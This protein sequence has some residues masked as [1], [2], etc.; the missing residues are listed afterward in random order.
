MKKRG[1]GVYIF[2]IGGVIL[3]LVGGFLI[4]SSPGTLI[5]KS[6]NILWIALNLIFD[7]L[8]LAG[9]AASIGVLLLK[10][11]ARRLFMAASLIMLVTVLYS[12]AIVLSR[13]ELNIK[14][15]ILGA[16][17]GIIPFS[18]PIIYFRRPKVKEQFKP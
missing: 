13:G 14:G 15:F 10:N 16:V 2:G 11:W 7:I 17:V 1:I 3:S 4:L 6:S 5:P 12:L 18:L 8:P 9:L